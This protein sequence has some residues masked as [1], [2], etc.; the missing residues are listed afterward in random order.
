MIYSPV[1]QTGVNTLY[2]SQEDK[3]L[4]F[5]SNPAVIA[6]LDKLTDTYHCFKTTAYS[7][8]GKDINLI[9]KAYVVNGNLKA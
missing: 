3:T 8:N 6:V 5:V 7:F 4:L 9:S 2:N 1:G